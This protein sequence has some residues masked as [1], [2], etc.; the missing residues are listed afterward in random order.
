MNEHTTSEAL[1]C[2]SCGA[3]C[4]EAFDTTP[5]LP[6]EADVLEATGLVRRHADGWLDL[7]RVPGLCGATRCGALDGPLG[8]G[9]YPC[10]IYPDRPEACRELE[11]GG[12]AC[13]LARRR[14]GLE[15]WPAG[16]TP[17]G[18]WAARRD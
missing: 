17:D 9:P 4:R 6:E 2:L 5:L 10:A 3:C 18:P 7:V 12:D 16:V 8:S 15:P 11:V 13:R 1:D 14:V